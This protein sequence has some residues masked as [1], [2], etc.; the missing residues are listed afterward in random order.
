MAL[1]PASTGSRRLVAALCAEYQSFRASRQ[2][3]RPTLEVP[4]QCPVDH[5]W[6]LAETVRRLILHPE[7]PRK[8]E[9]QLDRG[10]LPGAAE[11]ISRLHGDLRA[12]ERRTAGV[13]HQVQP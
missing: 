11:G 4:E 10:Q 6:A 2:G 12:V 13:G 1:C 8:R 3:S 5:D 9:I 7:P